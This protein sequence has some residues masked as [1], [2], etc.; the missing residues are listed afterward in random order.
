MAHWEKMDS[1]EKKEKA[2]AAATKPVADKA[3]DKASRR[4]RLGLGGTPRV[5]VCCLKAVGG[6]D[7]QRCHVC[8]IFFV[9]R[10]FLPMMFRKDFSLQ[11]RRILSILI[12]SKL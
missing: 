6:F 1:K 9:D 2:K 12:Y 5:S 3:A 8:A 7:Q 11:S 10:F 4:S